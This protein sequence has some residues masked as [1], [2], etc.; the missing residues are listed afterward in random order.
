[1]GRLPLASII[2]PVYNDEDTIEECLRSLIAQDYP[3]KE[4]IVVDDGSV[5]TTPQI[6]SKISKEWPF[7]KT[8]RV[9]H[10]GAAKARNIGL[11][12]AKGKII[13]FGE[14]DAIYNVD[15]LSKVAKILIENPKIGAVCVTGAPWIKKKTFVGMCMKIES[16]IKRKLLKLGK[17][18]PYYAWVFRRTVLDAVGGFDERLFQAEDKDIFLR[19]KKLPT[20]VGLVTEVNWYH[21]RDQRLLPYLRRVYFGSKSR[22]L[23]IAKHRRFAELLRNI[24]PLW[25]AFALL[26]VSIQLHFVFYTILM[27]FLAFFFYKL[28][29]V[30]RYGLEF[31]EKRRYLLMFPLFSIIRY[32]TVGLGYTHGLL[33]FLFK[34]IKGERVDWTSFTGRDKNEALRKRS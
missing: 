11:K 4:I 5:D 20:D 22:T 15:Y 10:S 17:I 14:G 8:I 7:I 23:Y 27:S 12:Y 30:L 1:M 25:T 2:V 18:K 26:L 33:T 9:K 21:K 31:A 6:L 28:I 13:F 29:F 3:N 16:G 24:G 32:V 34:K 19:V